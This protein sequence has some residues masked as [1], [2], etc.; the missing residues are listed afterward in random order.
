MQ[1]KSDAQLLSEYAEQGTEAAF[2]EIVTRHTNL[3]YSAALRQTDSPDLAAEVAQRAFIALAQ[4]AQSLA[5][6]LSQNTSLAGWLCRCARNISLNLRRDQFRRHSRE[7]LAMQELD[8][9]SEPAPDWESLR[10]VLDDAMSDLDETDYDA[11]VMRFFQNQDLRSVGLALGVSDDTA[12]KRVARALDKLRGHLSARGIKTSVVALS[13][14]LSANAVHA[15]PAGLALT[16][17]SAATLAGT[18]LQ[19]ST[20]VAATKII[21]MTTLQKT[22][23]ATALL[24]AV[25]AGIYEAR[26]ASIS[27]RQLQTLQQQ[28][29]LAA[30][31]LQQAQ[32]ERDD[33]SSRLAAANQEIAQWESRQ[34][35]NEVLKLRGQVGTLRQQLV[36]SE[37]KANSGA[38]AKMMS[39][40]AMKEYIHQAMIDLIKRRYSALFLELK[41]TPDQV[42]KFVQVTGDTFQKSA[43]ELAA[44]PPGAINPAEQNRPAASEMP[45]LDKEL[46]SILG[47]SGVA[48][49]KEYSQEVPA[50]T[51]V[52]LL[53]THLGASKLTDEQSA[54]LFQLVKAEPFEL[55][56]GISGDLD[57]A[58]LGSQQDIDNHISKVAESNQR[59]IQQA[60]AFLNSDQL[61]ALSHVL[62]NGITARVTQGAALNQKPSNR[63]SN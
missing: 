44:S 12:Q 53:N 60:G 51:T 5:P 22:L 3:V 9:N 59:V 49:F 48:R 8:P 21:A 57:Q 58:F 14:A 40:P 55:T 33:A 56:H 47:A 32:R 42:E 13:M 34:K 6:R 27:R 2:S 43:Q 28:Q 4:G 37:N 61:A 29:G 24:I 54:R 17:S 30:T 39:D 26:Q 1:S 25:G 52:D 20:A 19:T 41:L 11:L 23:V 35:S 31:Q 38:F 10:P 46:E 36:S 7:R 62:S 18:A 63:N 45:G 16:I 15:A 50:R